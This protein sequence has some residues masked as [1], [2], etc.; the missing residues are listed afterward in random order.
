MAWEPWRVR[1]C[2]GRHWM[3][4]FLGGLVDARFVFFL[5]FG[6]CAFVGYMQIYVSADHERV[7]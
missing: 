1:N 2:N 3:G 5:R 6:A 7:V 4:G